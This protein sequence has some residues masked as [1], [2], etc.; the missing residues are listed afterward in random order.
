[1][2]PDDRLI[3]DHV[4]LHPSCGVV[5]IDSIADAAAGEA[6]NAI[7]DR[8]R[9]FLEDGE[10]ETFFP[11]FLPVVR[12]S[13]LPEQPAAWRSLLTEAFAD[14]PLLTIK[15]GG[16]AAALTTVVASGGRRR[17]PRPT[18][19]PQ[20]ERATKEQP[21][22]SFAVP[23]PAA[24]EATPADMAF[25]L[26]ADPAAR[27]MPAQ[28]RLG[29]SLWLAGPLVAVTVVAAELSW[30]WHGEIA[31]RATAPV[32]PATMDS[33]K[34]TTLPPPAAPAV[35]TRAAPPPASAPTIG[36]AGRRADIPATTPTSTPRAAGDEA[37]P[38]PQPPPVTAAQGE[39]PP[40]PAEKPAFNPIAVRSPAR[41]LLHEPAKR[42]LRYESPRRPHRV[43]PSAIARDTDLTPLGSGP[44]IDAR[45]LPPLEPADGQ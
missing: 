2:P 26:V 18:T 37:P 12:L 27:P 41:A 33:Q 11:G 34:I 30:F 28:H 44:P 36:A 22:A 4:L 38:M 23:P 43:R 45:D 17:D 10:F 32:R 31:D 14:A 8:F 6:G 35:T 13:E 21:A 5:L 29:R 19:G 16:W 24:R 40:I 7:V 9:R 3:L 20:T 1:M 42:A 39:P 25:R 15:D